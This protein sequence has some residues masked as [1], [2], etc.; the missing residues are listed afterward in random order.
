MRT[1]GGA[2]AAGLLALGG[3]QAAAQVSMGVGRTQAESMTM[4]GYEAN[5]FEGETCARAL[6]TAGGNVRGVFSGPSGTYRLTVRYHDENDGQAMMTLRVAGVE[7]DSWIL[8]ADDH[9]WKTRTVNDVALVAGT[10]I[11]L[12]GARQA[13]EHARVDFIEVAAPS[14]GACT[15]TVNVA[16]SAALQAAAADAR[17]GD[18]IVAANGA[19]AGFA[20]T[21]D[22]TASRPIVVRAASRGG[23]VITSGIVRLNGANFVTLEGFRITSPGGQATLDGESRRVIVSLAGSNDCRVTRNTFRP[24]GHAAS[25]NY[26]MIN[27]NSRRNRIDHNDFGPNTVDGVH[28]IFASGNRTIAGAP[29]PNRAVW[30]NG[31][32]PVNPN[33]ARD[34]R[35]DHNHFHDLASGTAEAIVLGGL[36]ITGDYQD[37]NT[38]V[39]LNLFTACDGDP[40]VV[41]IKSSS[42]VVRYNTLRNSAG[43]IV[44]RAGNKS[45]IYGNFIFGSNKGGSH[46]VRIHEMDHVVYNNYIDNTN[47]YPMNIASGHSYSDASF[48]HARVVRARV[49]HNTVV[50]AGNRPVIIGWGNSGTRTLAPLDSVFANNLVQG[51]A[52]LFAFPNP[53]NTVFSNNVVGGS[54]GSSRPASQ[55]LVVDPQLQTVGGLRKLGP[56]SPAIGFANPSFFPFVTDD[57]DGQPRSDPDAGADEFSSVAIG[58]RPLSA[59]DVGPD[60]P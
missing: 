8:N 23:A 6:S 13:G 49:V 30:A 56:G 4:S 51:T 38:I 58:R 46:G 7:V 44:S 18:C 16:S 60:A 1:V 10:E 25:T 33:M 32:G 35:I 11:R 42:N 20:V 19:Y 12:E 17:A 5:T 48:T 52:T 31:G 28:Y 57:M 36:G 3:T 22:G 24:S 43:G 40:E 27:G 37:L 21:A 39:E 2:V 41:S 45:Q 14:T 53:G 50:N 15:R 26:V 55:F 54:L 29:P 59:V 9:V 34:T 47:D